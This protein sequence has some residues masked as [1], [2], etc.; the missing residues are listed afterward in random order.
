MSL[1]RRGNA[2]E[3]TVLGEL[4]VTHEGVPLTLPSSRKARGL[5]GYL[6]ATARPTRRERLCELFWDLPDDPRGALRWAL[7]KLRGVV[8]RD[9]ERVRADRERVAFEAEGAQIDWTTIRARLHDHPPVIPPDELREME[10]ALAR[11]LLEGLDAAGN[12]DWR[13]WLTAERE[14][15]HILHLEVLCRLALHPELH[16]DELIVWAR[17]WKEATPL[18]ER[19]ARALV[20][21]LAGAGRIE[22]AE[23]AARSFTEAAMASGLTLSEP[24]AV[25]PAEPAPTVTETPPRRL[26]RRQSIGFCRAADGA[27]IAFATVGEGPP[28]VK[29]ANWL[30]HLELD[31][32]SPIWGPTF[33]ACAKSRMFLR[34]D[35]RG[36]GL[37]DWEVDD[38]SF[39]AFVRD[40]ETVVDAN[41]LERFPLLGISQG[42][43]VSIAYAARHP[44]RVSALLL[45]SGYATGWRIGASAEEQARREAVLILTRHGWGTPN[46]AY[47]H[48]FSQTFMP[49]AEPE[50]LAWFD[51]FQRQSTSPEN[52]VRFQE[53]F[54]TIDVRED[55]PRV[56]CPTIVFHAR[57][58]RR[59]TLAQGR[60][61]AIG[62]PGARFVPLEGRNHVFLGGEPAWR[63]CLAECAD[64]LREVE[65]RG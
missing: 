35:E 11:P 64:F 5:L 40:L 60:E 46:P 34:Y 1:L 18:Q 20:G 39:E 25:E 23:A 45:V 8:D 7:S 22:E 14:D 30:N 3:I 50:D 10:A 37:S 56:Q 47:R 48:I 31:W 44:E 61:V 59:I 4:Q 9:A 16:D 58:D 36:C 55:L 63:Q 65:R 2:M 21:A 17:R 62:I 54:G 32:G 51:E 29:A 13:A 33:E 43:A 12:E 57:D 42:A 38:I 49:D 52:A 27:R 15:A 24:F 41:G 6:V 26:L 28:L 53:A 19:S